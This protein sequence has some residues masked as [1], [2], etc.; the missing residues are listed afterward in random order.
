MQRELEVAV[1]AAGAAGA[2]ILEV[3]RRPVV[4]STEKGD[5][6]GPLT[7]ADLASNDILIRAISAAF[8]GDAILSEETVDSP[9]RLTNARCWVIDPLDGTKEFTEK[10]PQ[11]VVSV[12][13]A[14]AGRPAVGVLFNPVTGEMFTGVVGRGATYNG[15]PCRVTGR[16]TLDG[17]RL[18]VSAT[19]TKKGWFEHLK[20]VCETEPMG[21]VAYKFG[22]VAA[23]LADATFTPKPRNEWDLLGGAACIVAA[24]GRA[25]NGAGEDYTFNRADPLHIGVC[26]TN[27][28]LHGAILDLMHRRA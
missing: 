2:A 26:G 18:L 6:K 17:A 10:I 7:E 27:G 21:S 12:G 28:A 4:A 25:T 23:G 16:A 5:G 19:E 22:L 11:F 13:L 14:I 3:Y 1:E 24:G 20:G 15:A 8:P 9:E